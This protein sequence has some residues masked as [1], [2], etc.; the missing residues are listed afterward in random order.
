MRK[1]KA[2]PPKLTDADRHAR[3]VDMAREVQA[4]EDPKDFEKAF[5]A[6]AP[7]IVRETAA[8]SSSDE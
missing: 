7:P 5:K 4:S 8:P 3:F 1:T 2:A 6:V